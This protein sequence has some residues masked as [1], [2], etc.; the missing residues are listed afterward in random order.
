MKSFFKDKDEYKTLWNLEWG[1]W[2]D[3]EETVFHW[4][5]VTLGGHR[6]EKPCHVGHGTHKSAFLAYAMFGEYHRL[7]GPARIWFEK[8]EYWIHGIELTNIYESDII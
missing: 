3:W 1:S 7:D 4:C 2:L 6:K 8:Q 5:S